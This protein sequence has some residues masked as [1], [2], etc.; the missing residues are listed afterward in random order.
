LHDYELVVIVNPSIADDDVAKTVEKVKT[1]VTGRGGTVAEANQ[2]GRKKL[3]YPIKK[4]TE[5]NYA[6][7]KFNLDPKLTTE[8]ETS[9]KL[10]DDIVRHML[11][12]LGD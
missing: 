2:W 5:G 11:V 3:A 1:F 6:L 9:L 8:L 12:K 7:I 4:C 10:S